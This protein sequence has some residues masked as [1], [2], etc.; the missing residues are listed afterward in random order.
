MKLLFSAIDCRGSYS[1]KGAIPVYPERTIEAYQEDGSGRCC[2]GGAQ[3]RPNSRNVDD[4]VMSSSTVTFC[5]WLS[6]HLPYQ[7]E[8]IVTQDAFTIRTVYKLGGAVVFN[9]SCLRFVKLNSLN[10]VTK[11]DKKGA[12]SNA[13]TSLEEMSS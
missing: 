10:D 9:V 11:R 8:I 2:D 5:L 13:V 3:Q 4:P 12:A 7:H 6:L 1:S